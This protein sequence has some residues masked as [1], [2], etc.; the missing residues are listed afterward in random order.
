MVSET[1]VRYERLQSYQSRS[2]ST[3]NSLLKI[4][5]LEKLNASCGSC[6][7]QKEFKCTMKKNK[8]I[9]TYNICTYWKDNEA[10]KN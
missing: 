7:F 1:R 5:D 2:S 9:K 10:V 8:A 3:K 6:K 4:S